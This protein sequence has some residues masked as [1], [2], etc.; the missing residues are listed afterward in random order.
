MRKLGEVSTRWLTCAGVS[1]LIVMAGGGTAAASPPICAGSQ[2]FPGLLAGTYNSNV[3]VQGTCAVNGGR[4]VVRGNLV[5]QPGSTLVAAFAI[6][7]RTGVG[8]SNLTV[9]GNV[10]VQSGASLLLGC[11]PQSF[12]CLDDP[13]L[14]MPEEPP[15]LSSRS[16]VFG[17][18]RSTG[19]LSV[20]AHNDRING[21]LSQRGGGGGLTCEPEGSETFSAYEDSTINGNVNVTGM[22]SCWLGLA[23]LRVRGNVNLTNN[24]LFDPDAIEILANTISGNLNC[25]NNSMVWNSAEEH[26]SSLFPRVPLPNKVSGRRGGQCVLASPTTEGGPP[27]PGPF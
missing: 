21:N 9:N 4:A 3:I 6:N 17:N 15:T 10:R 11:D 19:A 27:G 8:P 13:A 2:Q 5:I 7:H 14:K 26:F 23:R 12:P 18:L 25:R 24:Q 20:I 1:G 16:R 22:E